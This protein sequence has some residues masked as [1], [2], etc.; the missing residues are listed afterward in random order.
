MP[1]MW[2]HVYIV[3]V[4]GVCVSCVCTPVCCVA[5]VCE[6]VPC[7]ACDVCVL[8]PAAKDAEIAAKKLKAMEAALASVDPPG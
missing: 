5:H 3:W 2:L 6:Q 7:V 4:Y 8:C 1:C